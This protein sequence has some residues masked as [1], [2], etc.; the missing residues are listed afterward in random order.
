M[1]IWIR[2]WYN[3]P[4]RCGLL[5]S[6]RDESEIPEKLQRH[7]IEP[8]TIVEFLIDRGDGYKPYN[9]EDGGMAS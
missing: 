6:I 2:V 9:Y 1:S 5:T 8:H 7:R 4:H 3:D